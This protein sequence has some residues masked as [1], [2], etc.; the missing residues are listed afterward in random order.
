MLERAREHGALTVGITNERASAMAR[1][2]EHTFFVH[3]GKERSVAATKTYTG[4][5]LILYLLAHALGGGVRIADLERLPDLVERRCG[6]NPKSPRSPS[7]TASC[8]SRWW[9]AA[10]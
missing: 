4:Q 10:A 6:W 1:L 7:A 5:M 3:A 9:W 8:A 2:A